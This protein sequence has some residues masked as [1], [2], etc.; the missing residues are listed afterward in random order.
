MKVFEAIASAQTADNCLSH[1]RQCSFLSNAST[2]NLIQLP[3]QTNSHDCGLYMLAYI[4][5]LLLNKRI[6]FQNLNQTGNRNK[7]QCF[8]KMYMH[9]LRQRIMKLFIQLY[10]KQMNP[11]RT[12]ATIKQYLQD[13]QMIYQKAVESEDFCTLDMDEFRKYL[14]FANAYQ[15]EVGSQDEARYRQLV[16]FNLLQDIN[17]Y[18]KDAPIEEMCFDNDE[19]SQ[20]K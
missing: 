14:M 18:E 16:R 17:Y 12:N 1:Q 11:Q 10:Q 9:S 5:Q 8:P 6:H 3:R 4:E 15:K 7:L 19:D 2:S 13:R 20:Y